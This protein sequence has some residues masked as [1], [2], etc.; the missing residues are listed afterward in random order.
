[1]ALDPQGNYY[2][3]LPDEVRGNGTGS[4]SAIGSGSGAPDASTKVTTIYVDVATGNIYAYVSG[5]WVASGGAGSN[6]QIVIYTSGTPS[7]PSDITKPALAYDPNGI[8]PIV[9]WNTTTHLW[10]L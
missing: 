5:A 6:G 3:A 10:S 4:I 2:A 9:G 7:N 1:M 8:Q